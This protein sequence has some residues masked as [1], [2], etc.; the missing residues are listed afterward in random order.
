MLYSSYF[1]FIAATLGCK[2]KKHLKT[3][4]SPKHKHRHVTHLQP[5]PT[6]LADLVCLCLHLSHQCLKFP[7]QIFPHCNGWSFLDKL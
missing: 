3:A 6:D 2:A 4:I 5:M 7:L 1:Y